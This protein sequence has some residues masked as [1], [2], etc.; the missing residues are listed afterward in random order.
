[1][2]SLRVGKNSSM[3]GLS[4][5]ISPLMPVRISTCAGI[6][7]P[8]FMSDWQRALISSPSTLAAATS[9]MRS[10]A[11]SKP[12]A[13]KSR[14]QYSSSPASA[15]W[16]PRVSAGSEKYLS[17]P[18]LT[19][20]RQVALAGEEEYCFLDFEA[21][22]F[23]PARERIIEVAAA[24]V[25][26]EEIKARCQSL[27]NPGMSIPAHVEILTGI[28]GEM[29]AD[30]PSMDEFFPTL[31][32]FM[33]DLTVVS[34][35]RFEESFLNVL[36]P[37]LAGVAFGNPYI[38]AMDIA[39]VLL[40][41]LRSH[42]QADLAGM[43]GLSTGRAHRA[44]DD[45]DTL[46]SICNILL[47]GLYNLPLPMIKAIGDRAPAEP[48]GLSRLLA[49]VLSERSGGRPVEGL[50]LGGFI[51]REKSWE[52]ILPLAGE[53]PSGTVHAEAVREVFGAG[54]QLASQ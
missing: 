27:I 47:G 39:L 12:V 17:L 26:G 2:N 49:K 53:S 9:M 45:V 51:K 16:R 42:R 24:R 29:V 35:S 18:A 30:S 13:S 28:S 5:T 1:M 11:G 36:Y 37:K 19:R 4:D 14:K 52:E 10:L 44:A 25:E 33:G 6:L 21:T 40:P 23:D 20:G 41:C 7:I 31:R 38:D 50:K 3:D 15:T 48:G 32:E 8:G 22:G 46:I 43:W 54:G 34:Y